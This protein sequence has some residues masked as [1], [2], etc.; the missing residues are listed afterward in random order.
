MAEQL[1][2]FEPGLMIWTFIVFLITLAALSKIAWRPLMKALDEREERIHDALTKAEQAQRA[3]ED[4]IAQAKSNSD[5]ALRRADDLVKEARVE[6]QHLRQK[7]V[8][9]AKAESQKTVEQGLNR[10]AAEQRIAMA[11]IRRNAAD[12][13]IRAAAQ[14]V[15]SSMSEQQQRQIVQDFLADLPADSSNTVQ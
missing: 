6:A 2:R 15:K 1:L 3:A 10:I 11:E 7:M 8:D 9:E 14:L 5:A 4:A 12:L 13:A